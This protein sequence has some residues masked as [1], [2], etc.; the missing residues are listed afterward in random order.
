[1][2]T[3]AFGD[4]N[5]LNMPSVDFLDFP[6]LAAFLPKKSMGLQFEEQENGLEKLKFNEDP[7]LDSL[8]EK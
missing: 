4:N 1:M 7:Q 5:Y 8:S 3:L 2:S 6:L